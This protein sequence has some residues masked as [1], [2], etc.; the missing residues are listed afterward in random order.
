M[1]LITAGVLAFAGCGASGF[2]GDGRFLDVAGGQVHLWC[3][4][5]SGPTV[6]F[7]SAIGGD[8]TL[9]PIAERIADDALACFYHRPGDGDTEQPDGPRTA[10]EDAADLHE[11]LAAAELETPVVLVGHSYGGL[12]ALIA[13]AEHPEETAGMV[14]VDA[15]QP[16]AEAAMDAVLDDA[17]R[18]R[19]EAEFANFPFVDWPTSLEQAA[20]ARAAFPAIPL[21][22]ISATRGFLDPCDPEL[23]CE[24]MQDIWIKAQ[25]GYAALTPDARHV[26]ADTTH[27]VQN[28]DPDLVEQEIRDLLARID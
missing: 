5:D 25:E 26:E 23:P 16:Q 3:D 2:E 7:L 1:A 17:Q 11:L 27:Y 10:A 8:D 20:D 22:V 12:I 18:A 9:V 6:M 28:D 19:V 4:G 21:T 13:A 15:S 14:L 24:V